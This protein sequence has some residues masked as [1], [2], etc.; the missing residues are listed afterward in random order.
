[1]LKKIKDDLVVM[2]K[3]CIRLPQEIKNDYEND[4]KSLKELYLESL[5]EQKRENIKIQRE[6]DTFQRENIEIQNEI[7]FLLG[8]LNNLEK[9]AGFKAR[10]YAYFEE[11]NTNDG[12][13]RYIIK[14]E[15]L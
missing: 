1:M 10:G 13:V 2:K 12:D 11:D 4:I 7:Y 9:E 3:D 6:I 14:T 8:R 15:N 5:L